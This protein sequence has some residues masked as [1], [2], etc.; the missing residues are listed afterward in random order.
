MASLVAGNRNFWKHPY[1]KRKRKD[2][3]CQ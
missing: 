1:T 3:I 2:P